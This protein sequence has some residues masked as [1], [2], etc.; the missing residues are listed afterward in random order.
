MVRNELMLRERAT[1]LL[2]PDLKASIEDRDEW[3]G[4]LT[5]ALR[6]G[7]EVCLVLGSEK[8]LGH[9]EDTP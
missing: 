9:K 1:Y 7:E 2:E 8:L 4:L 3:H 5:G 6:D